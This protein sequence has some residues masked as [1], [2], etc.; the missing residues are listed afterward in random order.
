M[1]GKAGLPADIIKPEDVT[2]EYANKI[3]HVNIVDDVPGYPPYRL[4][5]VTG[6]NNEQFSLSTFK[7]KA[8]V[9]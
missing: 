7:Y 9:L 6:E 3:G 1:L 4:F 8:F 2:G 5:N